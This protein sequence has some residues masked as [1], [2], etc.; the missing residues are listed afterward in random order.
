MYYFNF[1]SSNRIILFLSSMKVS[2]IVIFSARSSHRTRNSLASPPQQFVALPSPVAMAER[3]ALILTLSQYNVKKLKSS[4]SQIVVSFSVS[5]LRLSNN[6]FTCCGSIP[7][8]R[9][10]SDRD[11]PSWVILLDISCPMCTFLTIILIFNKLVNFGY[12]I[13]LLTNNKI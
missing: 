3:Y 8:L 13:N 4:A 12:T 5:R 10:N 11:M 2:N 9:A 7:A 1:D 6:P